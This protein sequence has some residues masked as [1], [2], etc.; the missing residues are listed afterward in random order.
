M[1]VQYFCSFGVMF[2][3]VNVLIKTDSTVNCFS[4]I[5]KHVCYKLFSLK[6]A[7]LED[8]LC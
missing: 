4:C 3:K 2:F 6:I 5:L 7:D 1:C 8:I